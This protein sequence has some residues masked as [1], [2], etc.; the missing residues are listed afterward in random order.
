[1]CVEYA[2]VRQDKV[3]AAYFRGDLLEKRHAMMSDCWSEANLAQT[4]ANGR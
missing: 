3:E 4:S 1:M 2:H